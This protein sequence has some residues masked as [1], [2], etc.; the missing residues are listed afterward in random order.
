MQYHTLFFRK[1]GMISQNLSSD[2]VVIGA[3]RAKHQKRNSGL[4]IHSAEQACWVILYA[5]MS[6]ADWFFKINVF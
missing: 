6:S 3:L 1:L 2:A 5:F 4:S